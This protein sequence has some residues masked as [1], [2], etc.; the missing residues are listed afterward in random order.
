VT[1]QRH[2][3]RADEAAEQRGAGTEDDGV[4]LQ[5]QFIDLVDQKRGEP[6]PPASQISLP[7][8]AFNARTRPMTSCPTTSTAG[9]GGAA[10]DFDTTI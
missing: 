10:I 1:C 2:R 3:S 4:H 5:D 6:P 7:C 9:S 8:S